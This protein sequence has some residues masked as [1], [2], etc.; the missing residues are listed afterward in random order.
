MRDRREHLRALP[1]EQQKAALHILERP[2]N[3]AKFMQP[4]VGDRDEIP[5]LA[6][7]IRGFDQPVERRNDP[8]SQQRRDCRDDQTAADQGEQRDEG[9]EAGNRRLGKRYADPG[10]VDTLND[11]P[12]AGGYERL[13]LARGSEAMSPMKDR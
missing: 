10:I 13:R 6:D 4:L 8:A 1:H 7:L 3:D 2:G 12:Q 9:V 11:D 5:R